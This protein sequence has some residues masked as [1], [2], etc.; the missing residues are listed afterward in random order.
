MT[1]WLAPGGA[2]GFYSKSFTATKKDSEALSQG[3][4]R[5]EVEMCTATGIRK[6]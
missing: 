5:N 4:A 1:V 2:G 6:A 3:N